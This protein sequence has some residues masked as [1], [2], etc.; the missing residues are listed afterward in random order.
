MVVFQMRHSR[1]DSTRLDIFVEEPFPFREE[2]DRAL[3]ENVAGVRAPIV[4]YDQ[5]IQLK[6][7]SGRGQD[8]A[9]IAELELIRQNRKS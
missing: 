5:L 3:W 2:Y 1:P 8:L 4:G 9:D 7:S 6:R